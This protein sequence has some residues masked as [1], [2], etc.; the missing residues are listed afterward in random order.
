MKICTWGDLLNIHIDVLFIS[1]SVDKPIP[2]LQRAKDL[3]GS[4]IS[5]K[6][7]VLDFF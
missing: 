3:V 5:V 2:I 6:V 1:L 4:P 7:I